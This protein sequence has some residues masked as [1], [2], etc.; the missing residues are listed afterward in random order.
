MTRPAV[1]GGLAAS[2][3][4]C[5]PLLCTPAQAQ[6]SPDSSGPGV[7]A[8]LDAAAAEVV[9]RRLAAL[10]RRLGITAA[11]EPL[12]DR[13]AAVVRQNS[14]RLQASQAEHARQTGAGTAVE[15][16][17]YYAGLA[18]D[19]AG[20]LQQLIPVFEALYANMT[21]EQKTT[22]DRTMQQFLATA[23]R[24]RPRD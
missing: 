5:A 22:A 1:L 18:Q 7:S 3:L 17:R 16:L 20:E 24:R 12:W 15:E 19:H 4:L 2:L 10:H 23:E 9:E 11:Q 21:P 8:P 6:I 13:F 14:L